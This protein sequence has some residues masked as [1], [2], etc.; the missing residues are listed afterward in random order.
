M[1]SGRSHGRNR[2]PMMHGQ[3][4]SAAVAPPL[5]ELKL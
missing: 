2:G 1:G 5:A 4:G 3:G